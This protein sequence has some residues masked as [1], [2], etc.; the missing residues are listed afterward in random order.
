MKYWTGYITAAILGA[1]SW[2]LMQ[3]AKKFSTLVDMIY[4]YVTRT[5]QDILTE[6]S[7]SVDY[8]LWQ[9]VVMAALVILIGTIVLMIV[10]RW[11][12]VR[13]AGWVLA[14]CSFVYLLHT[15]VFGLNY[16]AGDLADDIRMEQRTYIVEDLAEATT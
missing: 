6:W 2:A 4:P 3:M 11:N 10:M 7:G 8:V 14:A 5:L 1:I 13:W 16:Y 12:P 9:T 15:L